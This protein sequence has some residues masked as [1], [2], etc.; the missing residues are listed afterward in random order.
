MHEIGRRGTGVLIAALLFAVVGCAAVPFDYP[1]DASV[2]LSP[3]HDTALR[4][5]VDSWKAAN[6]GPSVFFSRAS[7]FHR[8]KAFLLRIV[9]ENQL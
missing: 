8:F 7:R 4:R 6:P 9:P 5:Q 1:R 3:D 2:A